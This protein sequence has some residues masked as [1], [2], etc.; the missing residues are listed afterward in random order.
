MFEKTTLAISRIVYTLLVAVALGW[1]GWVCLA[2]LTLGWAIAVFIPT[3]LMLITLFAPMAMAVA[4]LVGVLGG[5]IATLLA[6][7][8]NAV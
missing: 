4:G 7:S 6:R 3:A 1:L 8:K 2:N 5:G